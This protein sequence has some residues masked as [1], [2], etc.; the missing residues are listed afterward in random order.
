MGFLDHSTNNIIID[1]V[2]TDRG[3]ELLASNN[4]N[5]NITHY[6][7][8]DDEIDYSIIKKFGR[9]VGKEKIEKN[10]PIFEAQTLANYALKYPLL[11]IGDPTIVVFPSLVLDSSLSTFDGSTYNTQIITVNSVIS[12]TNYLSSGTRS[13][14]TD[15]NFYITF[16][17]RFFTIS[18]GSGSAVPGTFN[19]TYLV[20]GTTLSTTT[21]SQVSFT[22]QRK[23]TGTNQTALKNSSGQIETLI[24]VVGAKTGVATNIVA[25]IQY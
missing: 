21:L 24:K 18:N 5:F 13:M 14:L 6:G 22:L 1:A 11:I 7:F 17:S 3:R 9:T 2:L 23:D 20:Q 15:T 10:T 19:A 8:G 4:G 25:T 12:E 16:D